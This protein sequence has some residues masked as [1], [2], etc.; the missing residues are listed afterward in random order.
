MRQAVVT[1]AIDNELFPLLGNVTTP[2]LI[3]T[4]SMIYDG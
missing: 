4:A 2:G 1:R 3:D